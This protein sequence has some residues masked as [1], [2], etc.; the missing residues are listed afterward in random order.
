[1]SE[2]RSPIA[3]SS[4]QRVDDRATNTDAKEQARPG[5]GARGVQP[6]A[7]LVRGPRTAGHLLGL[8]WANYR[9]PREPKSHAA[10]LGRML[11]RVNP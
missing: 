1:M 4:N 3:S 7:H 11:A 6:A 10:G 9:L 5:G 8:L 2:L